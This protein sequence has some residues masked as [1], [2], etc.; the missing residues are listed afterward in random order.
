MTETKKLFRLETAFET[1]LRGFSGRFVELANA[2]DRFWDCV[3]GVVPITQ[4]VVA[5][6]QKPPFD[7]LNHPSKVLTIK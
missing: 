3:A 6:C 7:C 4:Q 2:K 5:D 1:S